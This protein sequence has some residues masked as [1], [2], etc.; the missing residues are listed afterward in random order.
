MAI[1]QTP[2]Q[3]SFLLDSTLPNIIPRMTFVAGDVGSNIFNI[4]LTQNA[5]PYP[6]TASG[7]IIN[8]FVTSTNGT[9][10]WQS[11]TDGSITIT[12]T[13]GGTIQVVLASQTIS[14]VGV[15][16]N[17]CEINIQDTLGN[18]FTFPPFSFSVIN[19][20]ANN[21]ASDNSLVPLIQATNNANTAYNDAINYTKSEV[22]DNTHSYVPLNKVTYQGSSYQNIVACTGVLPTDASKWLLIALAG[23]GTNVIASTTNGNVKINGTETTVYNDTTLV[24]KIGDLSGNGITE[25]SLALAVKNDRA[26]LVNIPTIKGKKVACYGTSITYG[27]SSLTPPHRSEIT[28]PN[29][30]A[31]LT[32]A[33]VINNGVMGTCMATFNNPTFDVNAFCN[34]VDTDDFSSFDYLFIEYGTNDYNNSVPM[35][36]IDVANKATFKGAWRYSLLKLATNYPKL[37]IIILTPMFSTWSLIK[38]SIGYTMLDYVNVVIDM[39]TRFNVPLIDLQYGMGINSANITPLTIDNLHPTEE[40]YI[41]MGTFI[42]QSMP[43]RAVRSQNKPMWNLLTLQNGTVAYNGA[44]ICYCIDGSG[45]VHLR[46]LITTVQDVVALT[47]PEECKP[48]ILLSLG[49]ITNDGIPMVV[50]VYPQGGIIFTIGNKLIDLASIPPIFAGF[51]DIL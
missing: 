46:G 17:N 21:I 27:S 50:S 18:D 48:N 47:L 34:K 29:T 15:N 10:C 11:S 37:R 30:F 5:I 14:A 20:N 33:I 40:T 45:F 49:L 26:Q 42:V 12:S 8:L 22:Y 32:G 35:G 2:K 9:K 43:G 19:N 4:G 25:A 44:N 36:D 13:A 38:N 41:R 31:Q 1:I 24:N 51:N 6:L 28:Y 23:S 16:N 39:A 7:L 3:Y